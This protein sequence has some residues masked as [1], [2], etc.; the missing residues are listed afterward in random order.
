MFSDNAPLDMNVE[1]GAIRALAD[2]IRANGKT[3]RYHHLRFL[4]VD[5]VRKWRNERLELSQKS[6]AEMGMELRESIFAAETMLPLPQ[7]IFPQDED[8]EE[9]ME[10]CK[11]FL[12]THIRGLKS[13][14]AQQRATT[15]KLQEAA[16][17]PTTALD[18]KQIM[19]RI[20][21]AVDYDEVVKW[22]NESINW[23]MHLVLNAYGRDDTEFAGYIEGLEKLAAFV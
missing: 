14:S 20:V 11:V 7:P 15:R 18:L 10:F 21:A 22:A 8:N 6:A 16:G 17:K 2:A 23:V 12:T 5:W 9:T 1:D 19:E 3:I 13:L 4:I